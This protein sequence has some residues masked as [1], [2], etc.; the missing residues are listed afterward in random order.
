VDIERERLAERMNF[1]LDSRK[2]D[3]EVKREVPIAMTDAARFNA[4]DTRRTL[5]QVEANAYEQAV[6]ANPQLTAKEVTSQLV[7]SRIK[8]YCYRPFDLRWIYW[9]MHT[10]FWMRSAKIMYMHG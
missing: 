1:Y 8:R 2:T 7:D 5:L 9:E 3:E 10:S 4:V 6:R